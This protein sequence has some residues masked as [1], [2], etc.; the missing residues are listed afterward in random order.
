M[1][2][3]SQISLNDMGIHLLFGEV[4][5]PRIH[6]A[7]EFVVRGNVL[8][9]GDLTIMLNTIGGETSEGFALIDIMQ[10]SRLDIRTIGMGNV[11]SMGVLIGCAGTKGKRFMLKNASVMAHQFDAQFEGK[12]HELV[13]THNSFLYLKKQMVNHFVTNTDMSEKQVASI[14]FAKTDRYLTPKECLKYGLIDHI[15]EELPDFLNHPRPEKHLALLDAGVGSKLRAH[16][17][18]S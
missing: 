7:V 13:A 5:T 17:R 4:D 14:L 10:A 9:D 18:K 1:S 2:E 16:Q 6:D 11:M 15:L 8:L 12:F 3:A